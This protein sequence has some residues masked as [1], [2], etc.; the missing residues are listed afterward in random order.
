LL[1]DALEPCP[2]G[3]H[4][5]LAGHFMILSNATRPRHM[6]INEVLVRPTEQDN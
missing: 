4:G 3:P 2:G 5:G 1:G 6:S